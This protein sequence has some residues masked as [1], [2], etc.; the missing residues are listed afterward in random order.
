[1][2][3]NTSVDSQFKQGV[4]YFK[5][6]I[7]PAR[8]QPGW[9]SKVLLLDPQNKAFDASQFSGIGLRVK[10]IAGNLSVSANSTEITNYDYHAVPVTVKM[11]GQFHSVILPFKSMK[12][13]WSKQTT[14]NTASLASLSIVAFD[15][16]P[17]SFEFEIDQIYFY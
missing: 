17:A 15:V 16:Q 1:V 9:A 7:S 11:D 6:K 4:F 13:A 3:G 10:V 5:G 8:G 2:G 14:L 12:R